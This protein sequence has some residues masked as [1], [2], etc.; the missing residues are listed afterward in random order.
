VRP[1]R[2]AASRSPLR[3]AGDGDGGVRAEAKTSGLWNLALPD[4]HGGAGLTLAAF[5]RVSEALGWSPLRHWATNEPAPDIGNMELLLAH[6]TDAQR[7]RFLEPLLAG[8]AR[9]CFAMT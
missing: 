8:D 9:S 5:G 6:A 7:E 2:T 1:A 3:R 4:D